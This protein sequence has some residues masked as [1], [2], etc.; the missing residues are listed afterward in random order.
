MTVANHTALYR[1]TFPTNSSNSSVPLS[2]FL[3]ADLTDLPD[4]RSNGTASVD[5]TTG[6]MTGT[7]TF[8]PSFGIGTYTLH[9]CAD[10]Q[11]ASIRDTGVFINDR[12]GSEP[13]NIS[14]T[15][16][17]LNTD[18]PLPAGVYTWFNAPTSGSQLLARVG[19]SFI[20]VD[21]AC[22][23]AQTEVPTFDFD[24]TLQTAVAAWSDKLSVINVDPTGVN[25]S[26]Q[27]VFWS[28]VYR[29]MISPQDYTG[30]NPLWN[31]TEPYY[32]SYY[33]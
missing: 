12:A 5:P 8:S 32:D 10:Y 14:V 2:P 29:S 27:T 4:S 16:D 13:K 15:P 1:F 20:S 21:Q 23:N 3:L 24:G 30:E 9:F 17:G 19:V 26:M 11:G 33:W 6:Q 18:P 28:G 31:S 22:S 25:S 7:G